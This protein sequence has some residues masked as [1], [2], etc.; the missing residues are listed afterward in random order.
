MM[1]YIVTAI[2]F[3]I[4]SISYFAEGQG[5]LQV[6]YL[7]KVPESQSP[8]AYIIYGK[9]LGTTS[10]EKGYYNTITNHGKLSVTFQS[11]GYESVTKELNIVENDTI[12]LDVGLEMKVREIDQI[13]ISANKN[14]QKI[15]E[16]T[17]SM[18]IIKMPLLKKTILLMR[19]TL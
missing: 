6:K 16:L 2:F 17:V 7:I 15:A 18:D 8:G 11:I 3:L 19:R 1:R 13:V 10:D 14:E 5:V 12:I 9:Q 4:S